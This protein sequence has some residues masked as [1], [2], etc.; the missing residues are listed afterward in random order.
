METEKLYRTKTGYCHILPDKIV[1]TREGKIGEIANITVGNSVTRILI[2]YSI[3]SL[4]LFYFSFSIFKTGQIF[5]SILFFLLGI[6]FSYGIFNSL[7]NSATPIIERRKIKSV[8]LK[9][10]VSGL[11]RTRFEVF[12]EDTNG[13][14]KKRLIILPGTLENGKEEEEKAVKIMIEEKLILN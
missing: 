8:K 5:Q 11:T 7:N 1:L 3:F 6:Y 10:G 14:L 4:A 9:K 2:I 12:F 13:K